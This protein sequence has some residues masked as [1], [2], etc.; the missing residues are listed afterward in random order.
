MILDYAGLYC[1]A[2]LSPG[3]GHLYVSCLSGGQR[4]VLIH[5]SDYCDHLSVRLYRHVFFG[6]ALRRGRRTAQTA[7][8]PAETVLLEGGW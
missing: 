8:A 7:P 1:E 3:W 4:V 6:P 5:L 2:S